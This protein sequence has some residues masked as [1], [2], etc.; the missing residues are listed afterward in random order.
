MNKTRAITN[1]LRLEKLIKNKDITF[2]RD[3]YETENGEERF[4]CSSPELNIMVNDGVNGEGVEN[5]IATVKHLFAHYKDFV[6]KPL[7]EQDRKWLYNLKVLYNA[8][9]L[10]PIKVKEL[11]VKILSENDY[12]QDKECSAY[13]FGSKSGDCR[14]KDCRIIWPWR[15]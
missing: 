10:N 14:C 8:Y 13:R 1:F 5:I 9:E 7:R 12:S 6:M 2:Y 4:L 3:A 11:I 15:Y